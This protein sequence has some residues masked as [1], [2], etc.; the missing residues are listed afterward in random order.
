VEDFETLELAL[1]VTGCRG[2]TLVTDYRTMTSQRPLLCHDDLEASML[3]ERI[4]K[5]I[6]E[7]KRC[8]NSVEVTQGDEQSPRYLFS[9]NLC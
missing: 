3:L 5:K 1:I 6:E 2:H 7:Q 9:K 4:E 8:E